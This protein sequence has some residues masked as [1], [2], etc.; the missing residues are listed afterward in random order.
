[1]ICEQVSCGVRAAREGSWYC[2]T[3][4]KHTEISGQTNDARTSVL[5][6]ELAD[7]I[8]KPPKASLGRKWGEGQ[9]NPWLPRFSGHRSF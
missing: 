6:W 9:L 4:R 7:G 1:M 5:H 3:V 2:Q 8:A